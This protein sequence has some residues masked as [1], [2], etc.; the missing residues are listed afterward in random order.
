MNRASSSESGN[1]PSTMGNAGDTTRPPMRMD[2]SVV[3]LVM[4]WK[5]VRVGFVC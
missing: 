4:V 2:R 1:E 3:A 5:E